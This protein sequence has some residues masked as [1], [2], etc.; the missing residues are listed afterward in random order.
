M[1]ASTDVN[2]HANKRELLQHILDLIA[3]HLLIMLRHALLTFAK[4]CTETQD[5]YI[6]GQSKLAPKW[7][8]RRPQ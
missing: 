7:G 3:V 4:S 2:G 6:Q 8:A 1:H 5:A